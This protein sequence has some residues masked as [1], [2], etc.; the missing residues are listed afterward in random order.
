V[1]SS[2]VAL[3][4]TGR[5]RREGVTGDR[6]RPQTVTQVLRKKGVVEKFVG[7]STAPGLSELSLRRTR[8]TL[9][10]MSPEYGATMGFFPWTR[11]PWSICDGRAAGPRRIW[12]SV[13]TKEQAPVR[14]DATAP[15]PRFTESLTLDLGTIEPSLAGPSAP[16]RVPLAR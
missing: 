6:S 5:L 12:S 10:N 16:T 3:K 13:I 4:L 8:A 1:A 2:G 9:A 14:T 15:D 11:K 7:I